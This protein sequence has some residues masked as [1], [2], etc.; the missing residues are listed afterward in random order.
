[1]GAKIALEAT[2]MKKFVARNHVIV[3]DLNHFYRMFVP[4]FI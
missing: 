1:M 4:F 3:S 2:K